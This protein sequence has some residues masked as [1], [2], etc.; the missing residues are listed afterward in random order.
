[1]NASL[2]LVGKGEQR[3]FPELKLLL[4]EPSIVFDRM[5]NQ[6]GE[7]VYQLNDHGSN[8]KAIPS[9]TFVIPASRKRKILSQLNTIGINQKFI[10]PDH[11]NIAQYYAK[12]YSKSFQKKMHP[13]SFKSGNSHK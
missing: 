7:F 11:D 9:H 5:R 6:A 3:F 13:L 4:H 10:Y 8:Q 2:S 1:I 12:N